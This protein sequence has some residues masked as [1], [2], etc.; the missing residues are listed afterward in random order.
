MARR[1]RL[2]PA[3]ALLLAVALA[4]LLGAG[5][6]HAEVSQKEGVRVSVTGRMDPTRLPRHGAAPIGVQVAGQIASTNSAGPPQL[7]GMAIAINRHGHLDTE[8]LPHCR[9]GRIDPSTTAEALAACRSSLIGEGRFSASVKIPEQSPFPSEGKVLAFNGALRGK[10]VIFAHIYGTEPVPTSY[11]L[12]FT[13]EAA[14]G[15]YGTVLEASFPQVT[16]EWGISLRLD[17]T[18][19]ANGRQR[20]YLAAGCPAPKGFPGATFPLVRT[21]FAFAGGLSLSSTLNR[22][23]KVAG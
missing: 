20:S 3:A 18:Y 5:P 21:S 23:C 12:P 16:G 15:T 11:V 10:P 19:S 22:S 8:G 2:A 1:P 13:I 17:R 6:A 7:E 9:L 4:S 14:K